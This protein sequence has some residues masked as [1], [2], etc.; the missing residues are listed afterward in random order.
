VFNLKVKP[1]SKEL[2]FKI[3]LCNIATTFMKTFISSML[4]SLVALI[5]FCFLGILLCVG[6]IGAL[7]SVGAHHA[8]GTSTKIEQNSYLVFDLSTNIT[9]APPAFDFSDFSNTKLETL[10]LRSVTRGI[11]EA[12]KDKRIKGILLIGSFNPSGLGTGF[13][14]L[15]EVRNALL[16]FKA[17]GKPIKAF[18]ESAD[19]RDYYIEST[20]TEI[21]MDPYGMLYMPGLATEPMFYA[22]LFE[23]Y[24][25]G[26]QVTRHG[27]YKSYVEPYTRKEMSPENKEDTKRLLD[28]LWGS[29]LAD[30]A[31][32]R[33]LTPLLIQAVV[34][35]EGI[36]R[37]EVAL[38]SHLIDR[39]IYK[40]TL[41]DE[42]KEETG[43]KGTKD[44]FKQ[45]S[46]SNYLKSQVPAEVSTS[47]QAIGIVYAEGDIVDGEGQ[48]GDIGSESF[49][50]EIRRLREDASVKAIVLRVNSPG[51]S[52]SAAE[53]IQRELR[54]AREVKPVI[55]SMG[56]YAASGG[57]W[58]SAYG[59]RI[60]AE[61]TTIT[62]S[63][64]VFGIHFNIQKLA[65]D[66]GVTFDGVKTGKFADVMTIS[67]PKTDEE[68]AVFQ[69]MVDWMYGQ[70]IAKVSEGR[71]LNPVAVEEIAQGRVW[72]GKE[73]INIGLV[74]QLGGLSDAIR[75]AVK[76]A[77]L[78]KNYRIEEYPKK[79]DIAETITALLNKAMPDESESKGILGS[80]QK[81][82]KTQLHELKAYNDPQELYARMP[83]FISSK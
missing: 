38:S 31:K 73:A 32:P 21:N 75:Y 71:K 30:L 12:T 78:G 58:I 67:K 74:D 50:R 70:F 27:K 36:L 8:N 25:V 28:S 43:R 76:E 41:L 52:A 39:A 40:D 82:L 45:I 13:A 53:M 63:I 22:G 80:I 20:A 69:R 56:S 10:Q 14:A 24:G 3:G 59:N 26:V 51:G 55:V 54:L 17:S 60:F 29:L 77:K 11:D 2:P 61:P 62:G 44:P 19:T 4:G 5:I 65:N 7:V 48:P 68:L 37:P 49:S 64:G 57:Y 23:K 6:I 18:L 83:L 34:D 16:R 47:K 81:T 35:K 1:T 15:T 9:D 33:K 46:F 66:F 72:T 79:K 42:L